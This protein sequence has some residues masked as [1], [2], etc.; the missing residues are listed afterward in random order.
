M[1]IAR[2]ADQQI[3]FPTSWPEVTLR[4]I[5]TI[6]SHSSIVFALASDPVL[7]MQLPDPNADESIL[8]HLQFTGDMPDFATL[9]LPD[10]L[11][12][13]IEE[14]GKY[15]ERH[16][17]RPVDIG[18]EAYGQKITVDEELRRLRQADRLNY[19]DAALPLLSVYLYP[20]VSGK[21]FVDIIDT[22]PYES[23]ILDLPC[24]VALPLAAFFLRKS[25]G[26]TTSGATIYE[27]VT[28][29]PTIVSR[30]W[31]RPGQWFRS[32]RFMRPTNRPTP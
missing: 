23:A 32:W 14:D 19:I 25:N 18:L 9:P 3:S 28:K 12:L 26:S 7:L 17:K 1:L 10:S 11:A 29:A 20:Q 15:I 13:T 16:I 31:L 2:F 21:P 5:L 4:Q 22:K 8:P 30:P 24:T 27:R 6:D